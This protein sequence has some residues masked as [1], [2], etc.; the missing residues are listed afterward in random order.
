MGIWVQIVRRGPD[1]PVRRAIR[2][3]V[4][5]AAEAFAASGSVE[6][7]HSSEWRI[8]SVSPPEIT[9]CCE[10]ELQHQR[11]GLH[12]LGRNEEAAQAHQNRKTRDDEFP[13]VPVD[14]GQ[15]LHAR[16]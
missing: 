4:F 10:Q 5:Y 2:S 13:V 12:D 8:T 15:H 9:G 7:E 1:A 3:A 16:A 6:T 14:L 11:H